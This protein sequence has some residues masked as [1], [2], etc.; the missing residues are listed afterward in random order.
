MVQS[1]LQHHQMLGDRKSKGRDFGELEGIQS[2]VVAAKQVHQ[3]PA[4]L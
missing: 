1:Q 3:A 2:E 4:A